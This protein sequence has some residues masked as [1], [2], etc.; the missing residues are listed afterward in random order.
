[1]AAAIKLN[2]YTDILDEATALLDDIYQYPVIDCVDK[3]NEMLI[4]VMP[5]QGSAANKL[6]HKLKNVLDSLQ[7]SMNV[8]DHERLLLDVDRKKSPVSNIDSSF[9]NIRHDAFLS[10]EDVASLF[11][12]HL[13]TVIRWDQGKGDPSTAVLIIMKTIAYGLHCFPGAGS[14]WEGWKIQNG[15]LYD[16]ESPRKYFHTT[17]TISSWFI[18]S[19]QLHHQVAKENTR[20]SAISQNKNIQAFPGVDAKKWDK[21]ITVLHSNLLKTLKNTEDK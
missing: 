4:K 14:Y 11:D 15:L 18:V 19:Q 8:I 6:A 12:V 20:N 7:H 10:Q 13:K 17:G 5:C 16:P 3:L 21:A 2:S 1:M 9:F